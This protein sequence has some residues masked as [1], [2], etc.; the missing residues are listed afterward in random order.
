MT[1]QV[2]YI[3]LPD[4]SA[5]HHAA[6]GRLLALANERVAATGRFVLV[7]SG[8]STPEGLYKRLAQ[9]P[10]ASQMPWE[11]VHVLWGDERYVP[12]DDP[13]SAYRMVQAALLEHVPLVPEHIYP[14]PTT[15]ADPYEAARVYEAQIQTVLE[16]N[17]GQFD[18]VLLG[19]GS[20]GHIASLFPNH[21]ALN[22]L[23]TLTTVVENA[24]KPPDTRISMTASALN[25]A[26]MVL[27]LVTGAGKAAMLQTALYGTYEPELVPAQLVRPLN[28]KVVWMVDDAAAG[29]A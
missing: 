4:L 21:P 3:V 26:S 28:G 9:Q 20:D 16:A 12:H 1:N 14:V 15:Y 24:P 25:R 18:L 2:E 19:M 10:L 22:E 7:L 8:G 27:F 5:I 23:E 6:A 11:H 29:K 13:E 17:Q